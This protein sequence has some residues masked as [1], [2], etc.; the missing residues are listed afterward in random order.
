MGVDVVVVQIALGIFL[1]Y[2]LNWVGKHSYSIGYMQIS[3][4]VQ[5]EEAPAFNFIF[6]ILAPIVYL[7]ISSSLLYSLKFDQYVSEFYFVSIYY[8]GFRVL[9]SLVTNRA[10]LINWT[11]QFIY[12]IAIIGISYFS[13]DKIISKKENIL[14]DFTTISNELWIIIL[15]FLFQ[16]INK[17]D[18]SN[19]RTHKR[20]ARYLK[21]RLLHFQHLYGKLID[22]KVTNDKLKLLIYSIIIYEDF[23][24]PKVVRWIERIS[25]LIRKKKHTLGVM[26]VQTDKLL[27]DYESVKKGIKKISLSYHNSLKGREKEIQQISENDMSEAWYI[28]N[29]L[30]TDIIKDYNADDPYIQE[31]Q[32]LMCLLS[33]YTETNVKSYL[34]PNYSGN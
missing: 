4:F 9:F 18:I 12:W 19:K 22:D 1:F 34:L 3:M 16:T 28:E 10:L 8:C 2:I 20:K 30:E 27:N 31:I 26:Q 13:W 7:F 29:G 25:F 5:N 33:E 11:K 32:D 14:P 15:I 17:L 23:N 24:R 21:S 6:R